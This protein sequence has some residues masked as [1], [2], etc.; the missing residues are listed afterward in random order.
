MTTVDTWAHRTLLNTNEWVDTVAP[1]GTNPQV[2]AALANY[3]TTRSSPPRPPARAQT[4]LEQAAPQA[5]FLAA[6]ITNAI[7][8]FVHDKLLAFFNSPAWATFWTEANR[9]AHETVVNILRGRQGRASHRERAGHVEP[10]PGDHGRSCNRSSPA[11]QGL[12]GDRITLPQVT[13]TEQVSERDRGALVRA[14]PAA[15]AGLRPDHDLP[16]E[17]TSPRRRTRVELFDKLTY[18]LIASRCC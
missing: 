11:A 15:P 18:A 2:T 7:Q 12:L 10:P 8:G 5:A 4:A 13:G 9:F 3:V 6:P 14:R 1:L 16:V 17:P